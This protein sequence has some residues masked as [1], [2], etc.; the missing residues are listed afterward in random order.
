[1]DIAFALIYWLI[2]A[3]WFAVLVTLVVQYRRN[4]RVFG[5]SRLLL[6][7]IGIDTVR[8]V[9]ENV[10]FGLFFGGQRG[11]VPPAISEFVGSP[12]MLLVPKLL[13]IAAGCLV[14]WLLLLRWLPDAVRERAAVEH[15]TEELQHLAATDPLTGLYNR[16]QFMASA[17]AEWARAKRYGRPLS[18]LMIDIDLFKRINDR[19]GHDAGD[20]VLVRVAHLCETQARSS[21]VAARLGGEEFAILLPETAARDALTVAD[22]L[23]RAVAGEAISVGGVNVRTTISIG[24]SDWTGAYAFD[25]VIKQADLA[26]YEAKHLG[27]NRVCCFDGTARRADAV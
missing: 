8:N 16:R 4:P 20:A 21:D 12:G 1:M 2:V 22:R 3:L 23:R 19:Y 18:V 6:A 27:R 25:E 10:L 5:T 15:E 26:L 17:E 9:V 24:V 14:L 11:I 13:N 7:V